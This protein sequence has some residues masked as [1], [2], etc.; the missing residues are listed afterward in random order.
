M[1][2]SSNSMA[3]RTSFDA[4][5]AKSR[6]VR[7]GDRLFWGVA[8]ASLALAAFTLLLSQFASPPAE[9]ARGGV[10]LPRMRPAPATPGDL[11]RSLGIGSTLWYAAFISAPLFVWLSRRLSFSKH[12][13]LPSALIVITAIVV[14]ALATAFI[15]YRLSYRGSP[16]APPLSAY[17]QVGL[18]TGALPFL[19]VAAAANAL[20]ARARAKERELEAERMRSQLAESKL[21]ALSAQ[22]QPHFLFNTLQGISTLILNDPVSADRMLTNLSDLLRDVLQHGGRR[23]G[24]LAEE[25]RVLESYL[26]ISKRRFGDR[27]NL[28]IDIEEQAQN[29]MV[30]FFVLQPLVENSLHHG[31]GSHKGKGTIAIVARRDGSKLRLSVT[32]DGPGTAVPDS[33]RGIGLSNTRE[34]LE[35]LYGSMQSVQAGRR[36]EGGFQVEI[37][38]PFRE[39][40]VAT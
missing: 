1:S 4:P 19:T 8:L 16:M 13:W 40:S 35:Q 38:I 36:A 18:I 27:L 14:L 32:D 7:V 28:A 6:D 15:Q 5:D 29:A 31:I 39:V 30:P 24:T 37:T 25:M 12:Q 2:D 11:L 9:M 10:A 34:R 22:L 33:R 20:E 21:A 3:P 17:L 26:E 23:E